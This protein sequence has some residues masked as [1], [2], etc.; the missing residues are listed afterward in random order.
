MR[1]VSY[2]LALLQSSGLDWAEVEE[3]VLR[4]L[5]GLLSEHTRCMFRVPSHASHSALPTH[6]T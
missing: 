6:L 4:L 3:L 1:T 5:S 2:L